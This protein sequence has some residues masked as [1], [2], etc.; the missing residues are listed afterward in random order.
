MA[1]ARNLW[2]DAWMPVRRPS[3]SA[4]I[5][6]AE[7]T[8]SVSTDPVLA[9]DWPRPD[10]RFATLEMLAGLLATAC[11]PADEDA[12]FDWWEE[13]PTPETLDAALESVAGAF[14][15]DGNGPRFLQD[16]EELVATSEPVERL[17]IEA[18]GAS[19]TSKNTD[20]LVKRGRI[21]ALGRPTA[22]MALYTFQSWAPAGGAG[23]RTGLRGGGPLVTMVA[24]QAK[25]TLWHLVW[26]NVPV[27]KPA[28]PADFPHI[29][30]WL[31]PTVL[32]N[33]GRGVTP[34]E[35]HPLQAWWGMPRRI[36]L[37]FAE[38]DPP[39]PCDITG[40]PDS[41]RVTGWRQR[42]NGA[43]YLAWGGRHPLTPHFRLKPGE[44]L[45]PVHPQP[46]GIGY[47]HWLG[48]VTATRDEL[49]SPAHSVA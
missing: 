37:D 41:V 33:G 29:F 4:A 38:T 42:P 11:P 43:N 32:S 6:P 48:L 22:A 17:L 45:L 18:P 26:A 49:R 7:L 36:R 12:W 10:F 24:P 40:R 25:R 27:G 1:A 28:A 14:V 44:E 21:A 2:I 30:P 23:N 8:A 19:T 5:R 47:R 31:A 20:L 34:A 46:G 16:A 13:P 39:T 9:P 35:A 3:G 15:L